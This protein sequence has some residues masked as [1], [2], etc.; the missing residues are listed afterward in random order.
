MRIRSHNRLCLKGRTRTWI[1]SVQGA[2]ATW[3]VISMRYFLTI[4]DSRSLTRS[5]PLPVLTRSKN[6]L[7]LFRQS[8]HNKERSQRRA[9]RLLL[10][11]G[12]LAFVGCA[13]QMGHQPHVRPLEPSAVFPDRQSARPPVSGTV[14]SGYTRTNHRLEPSPS[15]DPNTDS[16]PFA[17]NLDVL[18][19]GRERFGIYCSECHGLTGEGNGIVV[20]R[21]FSRPPSYYDPRLRQAPLGHFYDVMT[22][23]YGA[24][25]SYAAQVEPQDRWA[26]AAYIRTLQAS[27][28]ATIADVPPDKVT[29]LQAGGVAR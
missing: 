7:G 6:N 10:L 1:G 14:V 20:Q 12:A 22:N 2:V 29:E 24:M 21:G 17:L 23:G 15:F 13:Q 27:R 28:N 25:A 4:F 11:A 3:L 26:I 16:L 8:R 18:Q 5:L 9:G 19:R